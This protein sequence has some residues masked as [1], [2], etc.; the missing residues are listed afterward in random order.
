MSTSPVV[1]RPPELYHHARYNAYEC[2]G[3]REVIEQPRWA[4][5]PVDGKMARVRLDSPEMVL[6][7]KELHELDHEKC[8]AFG[9]ASKAK[10]Q[11]EHRRV[12][13]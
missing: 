6:I 3:C 5:L 7:W 4:T 9:D 12:R 2:L 11:R 13:K 10:D 8:G 1:T